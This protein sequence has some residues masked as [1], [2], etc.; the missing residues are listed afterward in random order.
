LVHQADGDRRGCNRR[1]KDTVKSVFHPGSRLPDDGVYEAVAVVSGEIIVLFPPFPADQ[2]AVFRGKVIKCHILCAPAPNR[3]GVLR[4]KFGSRHWGESGPV[5]SEIAVT[6]AFAAC[7]QAV[8]RQNAV[9]A[10]CFEPHR[11][12]NAKPWGGNAPRGIFDRSPDLATGRTKDSENAPDWH[13]EDRLGE[14]EES[15]QAVNN[16]EIFLERLD[17]DEELT[18]PE[19]RDFWT[20]WTAEFAKG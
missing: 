19:T 4:L 15:R 12:M 10:L 6:A 11:K 9:I 13:H 3:Y 2:A 14:A 18:D 20:R 8:L 1:D 17:A 7:V 5:G 16:F